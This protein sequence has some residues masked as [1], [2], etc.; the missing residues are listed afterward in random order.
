MVITRHGRLTTL[1]SSIPDWSTVRYS[2]EFYLTTEGFVVFAI[3]LSEVLK[4]DILFG[5]ISIL[6]SVYKQTNKLTYTRGHFRTHGTLT[7]LF[8]GHT[9]TA[10]KTSNLDEV[11]TSMPSGF[12]RPNRLPT[13][14]TSNL[15]SSKI[16]L[17]AAYYQVPL[18]LL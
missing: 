15:L 4:S 16:D 13:N 8:A 5:V 7:I 1:H 10:T 9:S 17:Q 12:P 11:L 2:I 18:I 14:D 6:S 3:I